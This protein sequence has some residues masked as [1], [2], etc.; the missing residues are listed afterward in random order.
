MGIKRIENVIENAF[1]VRGCS[2]CLLS[3]PEPP[4]PGSQ[5]GFCGIEWAFYNTIRYGH[6]RRNPQWGT[7]RMITDVTGEESRLTARRLVRD[8][9]IRSCQ[10][11]GLGW[12]P[13]S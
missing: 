11:E 8:R 3:S 4:W 5:N 13:D 9:A 7:S 12:R 2:A 1:L 6:A 10:H